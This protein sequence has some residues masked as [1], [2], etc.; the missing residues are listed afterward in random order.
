VARQ[1]V[2]TTTVCTSKEESHINIR[3]KNT[4]AIIILLILLHTFRGGP[5]SITL[6][7]LLITKMK[8]PYF[9]YNHGGH[10]F[11]ML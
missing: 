1:E 10:I 4:K 2:Y 9:T 8:E 5:I 7:S 6:F 11:P 3:K